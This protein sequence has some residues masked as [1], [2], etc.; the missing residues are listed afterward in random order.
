VRDV[1]FLLGH[2]LKAEGPKQWYEYDDGD[3][4]LAHD[5]KLIAA[6]YPSLR[7]GLN[8]KTKLNFLEGALTLRSDC[9]VPT[10][11]PIRIVFPPDYPETELVAL[12]KSGLF[13]HIADRHF[14]KDGRCCLWLP[15][16]SQWN[17]NDLDALRSF[18]DQVALFFERQLILDADPSGAWAWGRRGHGVTGYIEFIQEQLGEDARLIGIFSDALVGAV[19]I[20]ARAKCPCESGRPFKRC[21]GPIIDRLK[22]RMGGEF[23]EKVLRTAEEDP[24][25]K[26]MTQ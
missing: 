16:E 2:T 6:P 5:R 9:G 7:F 22:G 8:F 10:E 13:R 20:S 4:R 15:P 23:L 12:D 14:Y 18:L 3:E 1:L 26:V 11:I 21:H 19:T 24:R 25:E 17:G